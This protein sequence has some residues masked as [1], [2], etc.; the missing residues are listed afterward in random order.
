M[1]T[2]YALYKFR[3]PNKYAGSTGKVN[4]NVPVKIINLDTVKRDNTATGLFKIYNIDNFVLRIH[5]MRP[6]CYCTKSTANKSAAPPGDSI[7]I[8]LKFDYTNNDFGYFQKS[9]FIESNAAK[10]PILLTIRGYLQR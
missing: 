3:I 4:I 7:E 8:K 2:I 1:V 5:N 9:V 10:N 6:D